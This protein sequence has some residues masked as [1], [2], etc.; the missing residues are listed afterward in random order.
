MT[1][2]RIFLLF[3]ILYL[4][5]DDA[6]GQ[7]G[8]YAGVRASNFNRANTD[9]ICGGFGIDYFMTSNFGIG[10]TITWG[11]NDR[12][13]YLHTGLFQ[14]LV[15][16]YGHASMKEFEFLL[17]ML[18]ERLYFNTG[19]DRLGIGLYASGWGVDYFHDDYTDLE[20]KELCGEIGCRLSL[21]IFSNFH[22]IPEAG[23]KFAY[24]SNKSIVSYG[25]SLMYRF[26]TL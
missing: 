22:V 8:L 10:Y 19:T 2:R 4:I 26:E 5:S 25:A 16:S 14:D 3:S 18:P 23:Y 13:T 9:I 7:V 15:F 20:H 21:R 24:G 12:Y 1:V 6:S 17:L 11:G